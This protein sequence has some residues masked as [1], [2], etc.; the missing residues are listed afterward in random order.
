[1]HP[2]AMIVK[3]STVYVTCAMS[4]TIDVLDWKTCQRKQMIPLRWG[5]QRLLGGMP[6]ALALKDNTLYVANGGDNAL[7]EVDTEKGIVRGFRP[8]GFYPSA[9]ALDR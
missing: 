2:C 4:D 5:G 6:N 9:I 1:I 8:V 3:D 7:C